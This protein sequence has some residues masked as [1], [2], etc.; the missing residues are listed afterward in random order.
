MIDLRTALSVM[1]NA[2]PYAVS[3]LRKDE[4]VD[5]LLIV[6]NYLYI[7]PQIETDFKSA[8]KEHK[9]GDIYYLCGSSGDGKSEILTNIYK[10]FY[11]QIDFHLDATHSKGQHSSAIE[12][13]DDLYDRYKSTQKALA[14]GINIGMMQKFIKYGASRHQDI[15]ETLD[16][17]F[18]NRHIKA[19]KQGNAQFFDFECYPRIT[20]S[21]EKISSEFITDFLNN[22][23]AEKN[24]NPF[25][26]AYLEEKTVNSVLSKNFEILSRPAFKDSLVE[27]FGLTRLYDEQFLTPRTFV[28]YIY[29]ILTLENPDGIVGNIF[30]KFDNELSH[31]LSSIDP[32]GNRE[33]SLD[34]FYL[35]YATK[36]LS[37]ELLQDIELLRQKSGL[38]L[39]AQGVVQLGYMLR[40]DEL[41]Q[42]L[43]SELKYKSKQLEKQ[44]YLALI[45]IFSKEN[46]DKKDED[47]FFDIV[48]DVLVKAIFTY[49]NRKLKSSN[50]SYIV[51]REVNQFIICN[52]SDIQA[53][54]DWVERHHLL[55]TDFLPIPIIVN[56]KPPLIFDL[57]L[58]TLS[59]A[60]SICDGFKPNRH[61]L[62]VLTKF[63]ELVAHVIQK[64]S[65]SDSMKIFNQRSANHS[66]SLVTKSSRRFMV[67]GEL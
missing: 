56:G 22:L 24:K 48:E 61:Q 18:K 3:T 33:K 49:A 12:C 36:T 34:D 25:W 6:K 45:D 47:T 64:T 67:E 27:L 43:P 65:D 52:K 46:L 13:L 2:S 44:Y 51:S 32:N 9:L 19:F 39:S 10:E 14:I 40:E 20:F 57:D 37:N 63:D 21:N 58:N 15:K 4:E 5:S 7:T 66:S 55:S 8:L 60:I 41:L 30:S 59:L 31:K 23:T 42:H 62:G 35:A 38:R 16:E 50:T 28:D 11:S 17:F 1:S 26:V 29:Q 54:L 53:D